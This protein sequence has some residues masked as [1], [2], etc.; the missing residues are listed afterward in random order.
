[1][2]DP[3]QAKS[4]LTRGG[5][6]ALRLI[7]NFAKA[8][9]LDPLATIAYILR[10]FAYDKK[11][12]YDQAIAE[13]DQALGLAV[14]YNNRGLAYRLAGPLLAVLVIVLLLLGLDV[15]YNN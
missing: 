7:A 10:G 4:Y 15:A 8:L 11:G 3:D 9:R 2:G 6:F 12:D 13:Y 14:A 1:M 5:C